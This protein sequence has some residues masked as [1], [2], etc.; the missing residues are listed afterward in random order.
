MIDIHGFDRATG[1]KSPLFFFVWCDSLGCF[2]RLL[3]TA[4]NYVCNFLDCIFSLTLGFHFFLP[5]IIQ[6]RLGLALRLF[7]GLGR[8]DRHSRDG[9]VAERSWHTCF[10]P[11]LGKLGLLQVLVYRAFDSSFNATID[12]L[13]LSF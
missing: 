10:G 7:L 6:I 1:S 5:L 2:G 11:E 9:N 12:D 8:L 13:P 3:G 4:S